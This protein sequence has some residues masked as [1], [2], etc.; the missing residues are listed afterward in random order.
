MESTMV[1]SVL[2]RLSRRVRA[3]TPQAA[4]VDSAKLRQGSTSARMIW[5]NMAAGFSPR[6]WW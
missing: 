2:Y 3:E 5:Q 1:I 6:I 4:S